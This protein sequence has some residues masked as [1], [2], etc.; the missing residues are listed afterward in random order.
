MKTKH[1]NAII[2]ATEN[3]FCAYVEEISG[4]G[5]VG[6]TIAE[7]KT[8]L[9]EAL[10]FLVESGEED[11]DEVPEEL[12]GPYVLDFRM[13]VKSFLQVYSGIFTK[14]GLERLTGINQKQLWHY[15]NG[16]TVPRRAQVQKIENALHQL[17]NEL[18]SIHL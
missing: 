4:V 6:D 5:V 18:L 12:L 2:E 8:S 16:K 10:D 3:N 14:A 7:V 9:Q 13:D 1:L 15:A 11:G 17:G